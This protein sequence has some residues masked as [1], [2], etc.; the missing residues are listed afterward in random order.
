MLEPGYHILLTI[1][2]VD[3]ESSKHCQFDSV[4]VYDGEDRTAIPVRKIC[5]KTLPERVQSI[6]NI[7][8]VTMESDRYYT[9]KG[10]HMKYKAIPGI[11]TG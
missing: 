2:D 6:S 10:F 4:T 11:F 9:G 8:T 5:G 3:M 7:L 1:I